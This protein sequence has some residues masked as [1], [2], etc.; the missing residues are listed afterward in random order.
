M[1]SVGG[2][3]KMVEALKLATDRINDFLESNREY[4]GRLNPSPYGFMAFCSFLA[5]ACYAPARE[6]FPNTLVNREE[7][8]TE[9]FKQAVIQSM[10]QSLVDRHSGVIALM[11]SEAEK[12]EHAGKIR[13][14]VATLLGARYSEYFEY[15]QKDVE[16]LASDQ[17]N[18]YSN[19]SAA[20][21]RDVLGKEGK[22]GGTGPALDNLAFG[23]C[24]S[25]TISGLMAFFDGPEAG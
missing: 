24:L 18:L 17:T 15:F 20:F 16:R 23:L 25:T 13:Q 11:A 14:Q 1:V 22:S 10:S 3:V 2:T 5:L 12:E 21:M 8:E 4:F 19:L 7:T 6:F 9:E